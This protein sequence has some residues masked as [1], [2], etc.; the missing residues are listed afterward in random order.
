MPVPPSAMRSPAIVGAALLLAMLAMGGLALAVPSFGAASLHSAP[1][2]GPIEFT[3]LQ[4]QASAGHDA[5]ALA[6]LLAQANAGNAIAKRALGLVLLDSMEASASASAA[7]AG[8]RWLHE[9]AELGDSLAQVSLGKRYLQGSTSVPR[10]YAQSLHW[11]GLAAQGKDPAAVYYLGVQY[12][13]GYG[14]Q[15]NPKAAFNWFLLAA[16]QGQPAAM[17]MLANAYRYG[18]GVR[19]DFAKAVAYYEAAAELE[20]PQAVQTLAMAYLHGEMDL[21]VNMSKFEHYMAETA[22]ALKHPPLE[23]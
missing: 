13:N 22:H 18:D 17:F 6:L 10:D 4:V 21:P 12:A 20:H 14:L 15:A 23:P 9:A 5:Q 3:Q 2:S 16:E 11:F 19:T 1:Q 7:A 8:L